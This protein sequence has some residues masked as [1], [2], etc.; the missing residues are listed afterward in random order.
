MTGFLT[1]G[2]VDD[3]LFYNVGTVS[4]PFNLFH[5]ICRWRD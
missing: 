4:A 1:A 5:D 3:S 2:L